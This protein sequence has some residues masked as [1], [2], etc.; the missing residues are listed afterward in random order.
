MR[1]VVEEEGLGKYINL[2]SEVTRAIWNEEKSKWLFRLKR[3]GEDG[4]VVEEFDDEGDYFVNGSG[5]LK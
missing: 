4:G 3:T 2:R 5:F 1:S